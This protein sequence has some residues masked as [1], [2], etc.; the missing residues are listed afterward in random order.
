MEQ[1]EGPMDAVSSIFA[2][3]SCANYMRRQGTQRAPVA[4]CKG[5]SVRL[6]KRLYKDVMAHF[7]RYGIHRAFKTPVRWAAEWFLL[8]RREPHPGWFWVRH[9]GLDKASDSLCC[10]RGPFPTIL[11]VS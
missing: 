6:Y 4:I 7:H 8:D 10:T 1:S 11:D 2:Q 5:R 3:S 9:P